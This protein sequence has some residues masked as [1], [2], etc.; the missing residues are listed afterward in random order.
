[1]KV[2]VFDKPGHYPVVL[3]AVDLADAVVLLKECCPGSG[4]TKKDL[5]YIKLLSDGTTRNA[6]MV[7]D[8]SDPG[9]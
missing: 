7:V 8:S 2:Y 1:M 3:T 5:M 6:F 9:W 4:Y